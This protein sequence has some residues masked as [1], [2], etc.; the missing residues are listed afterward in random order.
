MLLAKLVGI[1]T[2]EFYLPSLA[3]T[4]DGLEL[5][6]VGLRFVI[7][8]NEVRVVSSHEEDDDLINK[9]IL[10]ELLVEVED[11]LQESERSLGK[12][13]VQVAAVLSAFAFNQI[14]VD[15]DNLVVAGIEEQILV[16]ESICVGEPELHL[17]QNCSN[18][19]LPV[20]LL[21]CHFLG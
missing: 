19:V 7:K 5:G 17:G 16:Q 10:G 20:L 2:I 14:L 9:D 1:L 13:E 21:A 11:L 4:L 18:G 6:H 8:L 3:L 15:L 12:F